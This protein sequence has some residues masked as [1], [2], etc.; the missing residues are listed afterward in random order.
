METITQ[1]LNSL[2]PAGL[3]VLP[4][5]TLAIAFFIYYWYA[6]APR[7]GTL[8]WIAIR[9]NKPQRLMFPKR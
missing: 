2:T 9:E 6:M 8:E 5:A 4:F 7:K 3:F 1:F